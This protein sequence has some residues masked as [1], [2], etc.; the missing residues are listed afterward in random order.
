M[1]NKHKTLFNTAIRAHATLASMQVFAQS[2]GGFN[3]A[4]LMRQQVWQLPLFDLNAMISD[5]FTFNGMPGSLE[6][7]TYTIIQNSSNLLTCYTDLFN[8]LIQALKRRSQQYR[9]DYMDDRVVISNEVTPQA[10]TDVDTYFDEDIILQ[11][12][13]QVYFEY[14]QLQEVNT[15]VGHNVYALRINPA[16][17]TAFRTAYKQIRLYERQM[18]YNA[19]QTNWVAY[20]AANQISVPLP[21]VISVDPTLN[22]T[23]P[24]NPAPTFSAITALINW[25]KAN[26]PPVTYSN[27]IADNNIDAFFELIFSNNPAT[28]TT[29]HIQEAVLTMLIKLRNGNKPDDTTVRREFMKAC[30]TAVISNSAFWNQDDNFK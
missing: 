17:E 26:V 27:P 11:P 3:D 16:E 8:Y 1:L 22:R 9:H 4:L 12:R 6:N 13:N 7:R 21:A 15:I 20:A 19:I 25:I 30:V 28:L 14:L 29:E 23:D 10:V 2:L 18:A 5:F 24:A